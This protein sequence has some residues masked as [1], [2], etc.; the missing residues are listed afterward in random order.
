M[1]HRFK[2]GQ[3]LVRSDLLEIDDGKNTHQLDPNTMAALLHLV[4]NEGRPVHPAELNQATGR[5]DG[6]EVLEHLCD[7]MN[8]GPEAPAIIQT[9]DSQTYRVTVPAESVLMSTPKPQ[10]KWQQET[11]SSKNRQNF[12][13]WPM[14]LITAAALVLGLVWFGGGFE[15]NDLRMATP[16]PQPITSLP[17]RETDAAISPDGRFLAFSWAPNENSDIHLYLKDFETDAIRQLTH[18]PGR[19]FSPVWSP[20]GSQVAFLRE[21]LNQV[22]LQRLDLE[23]GQISPLH[24]LS[25]KHSYGLSWSPDG[26]RLAFSDRTA[27][28]LPPAIV[29]VDL[30]SGNLDPI[31]TPPEASL[32]DHFPR[33]SP[34]GDR[35][36]F[37]REISKDKS[38]VLTT[39]LPGEDPEQILTHDGTLKGV[40]WLNDRELLFASNRSGSSSLM[41]VDVEEKKATPLP[42]VYANASRPS[43]S[44]GGR[45]LTFETLHN[46]ANILTFSLDEP[47]WP[48]LSPLRTVVASSHWDTAPQFSPDGTRLAFSSDRN[49][50]S[51]IWVSDFNGA[52]PHAL[53]GAN[54]S[55]TAA[56]R[57][58]PDGELIAFEAK[59]SDSS[60]RQIYTVSVVNGQI[61]RISDGRAE[62]RLP[63]WSACGDHLYFHSKRTQQPGIWRMPSSGGKAKPITKYNSMIGFEDC[64]GEA[65]YYVN[66]QEDNRI[67][68]YDLATGEE[69]QASQTQINHW[70]NWALGSNGFYY[71]QA[72][73]GGQ[74]HLKFQD[75]DGKSDK[76]LRVLP[77]IPENL[78][79][80]IALNQSAVAVVQQQPPE[81][82]I[83]LLPLH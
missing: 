64:N 17:G 6:A 5:H 41:W 62:D 61:Q 81:G 33:F 14:A 29:M 50:Y 65:F 72:K 22:L 31:S 46:N 71:I 8:G 12:P 30:S 3:W 78:G 7:L 18:H 59:R 66:H 82:D 15:V 45:F 36:A 19:D 38:Q 11:P 55:L 35:L 37:I 28:G 25:T 79:F 26:S 44:P 34:K 56:P 60:K 23:A 2:L 73:P 10:P 52:H 16:L 40:E 20:D 63:T 67:W 4:T 83:M 43:L 54:F 77:F 53:T 76:T 75:W 39:T 58:S 32:G 70:G 48:K 51:Q 57:W 27:P 42:G 1:A 47:S 24:V 80:A 49:G 74:S 21:S 69:A 13:V 9:C 68:R